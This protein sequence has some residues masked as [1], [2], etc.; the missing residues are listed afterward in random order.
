MARSEKLSILFVSGIYPPD[1]GGPATY[2]SRMAYELMRLGHS[3]QVLTLG[4]R[5]RRIS[6]PFP[7]RKI[8]R[9]KIILLRSLRMFLAAMIMAKEADLI[10]ATGSP[11]DSWII[12]LATAK[13]R[14]KRVILK[15]VG[16]SVWEWAQRKS[17]SDLL[18]GDFN[19][20]KGGERIEILKWFRNLLARKSD[21]IITP[22]AFLRNVVEQWG[23]QP[24]KIRIIFNVVE[25]PLKRKLN[26]HKRDREVATVARLMPWKGIDG[27]IRVMNLLPKDIKL[28][29]IG[30][31]P[32]MSALRAQAKNEGLEKRVAFTGSLSKEK[33]FERLTKSSVFALNSRYEGFPHTVLEAMAV[34]TAV[35]ATNVGGNAEVIKDGKNGILVP[36]GDEKIMAEKIGLL[37]QNEAMRRHLAEEA[38]KGLKDM[39]WPNIVSKTEATLMEVLL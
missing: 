5:N 28:V 7:V 3:I 15:V 13:L 25:S 35:V 18:M 32:L 6:N 38:L 10:Y 39:S 12:S 2:V 21:L 26:Y 11:W 34:G 29:V 8:I 1:I 37:F 9:G 33:V 36:V 14:R 31:G 20:K 17:F 16:D 4:E 27:L 22:S 30:D 24:R 19:K 23:I